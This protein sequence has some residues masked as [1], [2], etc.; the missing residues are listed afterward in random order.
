MCTRTSRLPVSRAALLR[1]L[2]AAA[3]LAMVISGGSAAA[4]PQV[5]DCWRDSVG[6]YGDGCREPNGVPPGSGSRYGITN[7][8]CEDW[9]TGENWYEAVFGGCCWFAAD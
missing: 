1:L 2:G 4:A 6:C 3:A 8:Y 9:I 7:Y 5:I